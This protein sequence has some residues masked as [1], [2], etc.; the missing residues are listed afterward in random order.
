MTERMT[1][2][3][4]IPAVQLLC[5][6]QGQQSTSGFL[7]LACLK[8]FSDCSLCTFFLSSLNIETKLHGE[9]LTSPSPTPAPPETNHLYLTVT[10]IELPVPTADRED[11]P[12][13]MDEPKPVIRAG[14]D[15]TPELKPQ[16]LSDQVHEPTTSYVA[17]GVLVK[18]DGLEDCPAHTPIAVWDSEIVYRLYSVFAGSIHPRIS[19]VP[20]GSTQLL[21]S[22][23]PSQPSSPTSSISQFHKPVSILHML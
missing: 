10:D 18:F 21:F 19:Y 6:E 23:V 15:I 12:A 16:A 22:C 2:T 7:D 11:W 13:V 5:L 1:K 4:Q 17:E 9:E 14:Y 20:A 3:A 8:T